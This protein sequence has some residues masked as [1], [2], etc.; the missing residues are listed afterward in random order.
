M[1]S[2]WRDTISDSLA[3]YLPTRLYWLEGMEPPYFSDKPDWDGLGGLILW[4]MYQEHPNLR[5]PSLYVKNWAEDPAFKVS[6]VP[7]FQSRYLPVLTS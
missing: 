1:I 7:G 2:K 6:N 4:A 5:R 3:E